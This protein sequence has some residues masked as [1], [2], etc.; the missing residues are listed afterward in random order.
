MK[1][2]IV[3]AGGIGGFIAA[4][5][6]EAG[7][8]ASILAR[9]AQLAAIRDRGLR[10]IR[11]G[12]DV[13]VRPETV[14]DDAGALG[15][16]DL[17][18]L[19]VKA[20]QVADALVQIAPAVG[21]DTRILPFQNGVDAPAQI[22]GAFG[23]ARALIGTARI[24]ANITGPGEI[25][26]YGQPCFF[27]IGDF[28]GNQSTCRDVIGAFRAAGIE[29]PDVADVRRDLWL[30]FILF[31]AMSS[32]TAG[33]RKRFGELRALPEVVA[34]AE[35]LMREVA[36]VGRA[37]G[38]NL[39]DAEVKACLKLFL[40]VVPEDGRTSTAHDLEEGRALE[41]DHLC[42][43]VARLGKT[44]GVP[45]PASQTVYALLL[46]WRDGA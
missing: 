37:E 43:A 33:S 2:A 10:L 16:P 32:L 17:I 11:K 21:P 5:M 22:A 39:T 3:G 14:T 44:H 27:N 29:A 28:E 46:P 45:V 30:K 31:N 40:E 26:Q 9:G 36:A 18:V 42:G 6:I 1:T 25:T 38:V 7:Q 24:F 35:T 23:P 34:L 19:S 12:G 8:K 41:I 13:T 4:K 20:H 15:Q